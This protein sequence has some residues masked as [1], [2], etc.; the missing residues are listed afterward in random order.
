[1]FCS[2]KTAVDIRRTSLDV[3]SSVEVKINQI[4]YVDV[5]WTSVR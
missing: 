2:T 5:D 4:N 1:M 3:F